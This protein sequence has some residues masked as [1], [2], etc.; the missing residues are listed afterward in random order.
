ME[1]GNNPFHA[2]YRERPDDDLIELC[3]RGSRVALET[4]IR[5]HQPFIYNLVLRS[6]PD[7]SAAADVTQEIL[8]KVITKLGQF[9]RRS[10]FRTWL[11]RLCVNHILD[12]K[13]H[14]R[15]E[16]ALS[17]EVLGERMDDLPNV[18]MSDTEQ[19]QQR[20]VIEETKQQCLAGMLLCLT[21]SQRLVFV[22]GEIFK[23]D[24]QLAAT[25]L[26]ITPDNFRQQLSRARNDLYQFMQR[27]CGLV[28][29][30]NPCRCHKKTRSFI[31]QGWVD[32]QSL[33]FKGSYI[34][35][36]FEN[37][38][39]R[40]QQLEDLMDTSYNVFRQLPFYNRDE[41]GVLLR[42]LLNENSTRILFD[43]G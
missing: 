15:E 21:R 35:Q 23:A 3:G 8:I 20:D 37:S 17:F 36:A 11:Y 19:D 2:T 42:T 1:P 7:A 10:A 13:R 27:K 33:T 25:F 39:D 6:L 32:P 40:Q 16:L 18:E 43:M 41:A 5:R 14:S 28:N 12:M 26:N 29:T 9:E 38:A 31:E 4:L 24:H 30:A 34:A 22:I